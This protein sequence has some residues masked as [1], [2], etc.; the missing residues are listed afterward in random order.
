L[1][2]ARCAGGKSFSI[3]WPSPSIFSWSFRTSCSSRARD[4]RTTATDTLKNADAGFTI[5]GV[6]VD[7]TA[8]MP[9]TDQQASATAANN[10]KAGCPVS[11]A[12]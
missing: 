6:H 1:K 2:I 11:K 10:A 9:G 12:L 5:T 7:L 3:P 4:V 8:R